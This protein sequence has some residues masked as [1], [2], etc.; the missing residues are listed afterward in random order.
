VLAQP[1]LDTGRRIEAEGGAAGQHEGVDAFHRQRRIE[2]G[3]L[4]RAGAAAAHIDAGDRRI[5][6][7]HDGRARAQ[8]AIGGMTDADSLNVC[9]EI[10]HLAHGITCISHLRNPGHRNLASATV[11]RACSGP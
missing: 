8:F 4:A 9:D 2:Q 10:A 11:R 3:G 6:E 5:V 1:G 7:Q